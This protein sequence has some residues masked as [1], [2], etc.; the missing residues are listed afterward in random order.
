MI[1]RAL[2]ALLL[3][4]TLLLAGCEI[5][6]S[7]GGT[8]PDDL[9]ISNAGYLTDATATIDG[10][11]RY[12]VCDDRLADLTYFFDYDGVLESWTSY[13]KGVTTGDVIG[14]RTF[15]PDTAGVRFTADD[16]MV[17]Y[18]IHA[19]VAPLDQDDALAPQGIVVVPAPNV[20]GYTELYLRIESTS[21]VL[22]LVSRKIPVLS[23]CVG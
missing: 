1:P 14:R 8:W 19:G 10:V 13:L 11:E 7:G 23:N 22:R 3:L 6:I 17:T 21:S 16:V 4:A 20:I 12:V 18:T 9:V 15:T 5:V 2:S